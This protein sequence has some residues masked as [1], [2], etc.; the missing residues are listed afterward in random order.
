M[1]KTAAWHVMLP[2]GNKFH[3]G[4]WDGSVEFEGMHLSLQAISAPSSRRHCWSPAQVGMELPIIIIILIIIFNIAGT[5]ASKLS[6]IS[7]DQH[8]SLSLEEGWPCVWG[9]LMGMGTPILQ[10]QPS[11]ATV[12]IGHQLQN[13]RSVP[14]SDIEWHSPEVPRVPT[15]PTANLCGGQIWASISD[16]LWAGMTWGIIRQLHHYSLSL[17][18]P[19]PGL[20]FP[21]F[22]NLNG[23]LDVLYYYSSFSIFKP[24]RNLSWYKE[25]TVWSSNKG[26]FS[27]YKYCNNWTDPA[28]CILERK[29]QVT[30]SV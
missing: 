25:K 14:T 2:G 15:L 4:T 3:G 20:P 10:I 30:E 23:V 17:I 16:N 13:D 5:S 28:I 22:Q 12:L 8:G 11:D 24:L 18:T 9:C 19:T 27:I 26:R 6:Y 1:C 7:L 21:L 29:V